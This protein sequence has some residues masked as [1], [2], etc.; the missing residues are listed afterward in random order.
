MDPP[1]DRKARRARIHELMERLRELPG[2]RLYQEMNQLGISGYVFDRNCKEL[3]KW[4]ESL[5]QADDWLVGKNRELRV[6]FQEVTRRLHN[7][8]AAAMSLRWHTIVFTDR[9]YSSESDKERF[10]ERR[11]QTFDVP[12]AQF[13]Q[14]LREYMQHYGIPP[15]A[16]QVWGNG[17]GARQAFVLSRDDLLQWRRWKA[18]ARSFIHE[19]P[20]QLELLDLFRWYRGTLE[21]FYRWYEDDI[22][23]THADILTECDEVKREYVTLSLEDNLEIYLSAPPEFPGLRNLNSVFFRSMTEEERASLCQ[24]PLPD[25][26]RLAIRI[27]QRKKVSS[28]VVEERV[29]RL[30]SE[31]GS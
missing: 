24:I 17:E 16:V 6:Y 1:Q 29:R 2:C 30:Y 12:R 25:R 11:S 7:T 10:K 4:L 27:L 22:R 13:I 8:V 5:E 14:Q 28:P 26:P 21:G 9:W 15:Q 3:E 23:A 31:R 18:G 19:A 20:D